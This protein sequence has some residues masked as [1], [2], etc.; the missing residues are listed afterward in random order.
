MAY[1]LSLPFRIFIIAYLTDR[2][3][4]LKVSSLERRLVSIR[5]A[6]AYAGQPFDKAHPLILECMKG[7]RNTHGAAQTAKA[8]IM[9]EDLRE[10]LKA[11]GNGIKGA[12]D[13]ALLLL[14]FTGAFRRSELVGIKLEDMRFC[15]EGIEITLRKSKTDQTGEGAIVAIPYGSD[16][17]TCPVKAIQEWTEAAELKDGYLFRSINKHGHISDSGL[18]G[19]AVALIIKGN[20]YLE[21]K[22]IDFAGHSLRAGFCTQAAAKGLPEYLIMRQS[23]HKK[24]DTLKK[25]IRLG[26]AWTENVASKI[27]L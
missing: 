24:S 12:R 2:A 4:K 23:R 19:N 25:Y 9:L 1:R 27:G 15:K 10:M 7:I 20:P 11:A 5:Q 18:S 21:G 17:L 22:E 16:I 14:G 13:R 26:T 8:P 6:H 3:S